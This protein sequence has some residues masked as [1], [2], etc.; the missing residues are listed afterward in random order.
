MPRHLFLT[1][2]TGSGKSTL[3][4]SVL[5]DTLRL[6]GG[7]ITEAVTGPRGEL[8]G[9]ALS[10]AAAAGG[11]AGFEPALFLD[12]RRFPPRT[13][14]EVFRGT[15]VR[16]LQEA[17]WYPYALLDEIGG[18][19][20]IIPQ[21]RTALYELLRTD[22][23]LVGA[24]KTPEEADAMRRA[25]GLGDKF[26]RYESELIRFLKQD[27]DTLILDV[28]SPDDAAAAEALMRWRR[29]NLG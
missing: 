5:G 10:P 24:L 7:F 28:R 25:L 14:N 1:G 19:E 11:V 16:L 3:L 26:S 29:E 6:A 21:F 22:L 17:P 4:R 23:P 18:F 8:N 2:P 12:C 20:L 13:D 9:L 15:G 27:K